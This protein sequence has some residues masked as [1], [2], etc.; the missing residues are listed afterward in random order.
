VTNGPV[1]SVV[2]PTHDY[3]LYLPAALD[4]IRLQTFT[5]WDCVVVDDGST[6]DT[7]DILSQLAAADQRIRFFLQPQRGL[8]AARN[9]GLRLARGRYVQFLDADDL[10]HEA[11]LE[12]HVE[13]LELRGDVDIVYGPTRYFDDGE[14]AVLRSSLRGP[15][16]PEPAPMSGAGA[17]VLQR[18]LVGNQMTVAAPLVRRSLFESVGMFDERLDRLED[19]QLWLRCAIAG[20]RFLFVPSATPV[21]LIR[22]HAASLSSRVAPMLVTEISLRQDL[23]PALQAR[24]ARALN[25][26]RLNEARADAGKMLGLGGQP[27]AA[28]RLMVPAALSGLRPNWIAWV[29]A[30]LL[31]QMPGGRAVFDRIRS[32][33]SHMGAR[34]S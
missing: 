28:L 27:R 14:P 30:L 34:T 6:D 33:R 25:R 21:A 12:S 17:E 4:S 15:D 10:L 19:W 29:F 2:V 1:V 18:L 13:A 11:K 23:Q 5:D 32:S 31:L 7:Q 8:S 24:A 26:R 16:G 20:K 9:Q 3:A 22:I